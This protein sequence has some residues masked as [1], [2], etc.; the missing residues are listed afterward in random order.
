MYRL[1]I[2]PVLYFF[3]FFTI[4]FHNYKKEPKSTK[5]LQKALKSIKGTKKH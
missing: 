1:K 5:K 2:Q 4:R 3:F